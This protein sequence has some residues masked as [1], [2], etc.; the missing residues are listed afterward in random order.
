MAKKEKFTSGSYNLDSDLDLGNFDFG[1]EPKTKIKDDRS[2]VTKAAG[3]FA[4]GSI[5][6]MKSAVTNSATIAKAIR[7]GMPKEYGEVVDRTGE[8]TSQLSGLYNDANAKIKPEIQK[9]TKQIDKLVPEEMKRTKSVLGKI[10][11][12]LGVD[13]SSY[14]P[15]SEEERNEGNIQSNLAEVF[16]VQAEDSLKARAEDRAERKLDKKVDAKRFE[17]SFGL[18]NSINVNMA[19]MSNYTTKVNSA[20]QKKSLELQYRS[21]YVQQDTLKATKQLMAMLDER[22][23]AIQKNTGLPDFVKRHMSED[24]KEMTRRKLIGSVGGFMGRGI[25]NLA[26]HAKGKMDDY[27]NILQQ[28]SMGLDMAVDAKDMMKS[29]KEMSEMMGEEDLGK[30]GMVGD[31]AGGAVIEKLI[32]KFGKK[33]N[34]KYFQPGSKQSNALF[35]IL[36]VLN[37]GEQSARDFQKKHLQQDFGAEGF[38]GT[39]KNFAKGGLSDFID[40]F[41]GGKGDKSLDKQFGSGLNRLHESAEFNQL[42][43]KSITTIIPGFLSRIHGEIRALRTNK[44]PGQLLQF[45]AQTGKFDM[46]GKVDSS[47]RA[48]LQKSV[49]EGGMKY[50]ID[51]IHDQI[52]AGG[53]L[54][55]DASEALRKKLHHHTFTGIGL[56]V[57]DL[58]KDDFTKGM[59]INHARE[60]REAINKRYDK[61][62]ASY[63]ARRSE[64]TKAGKEARESIVK[65][66]EQ[67][68]KLIDAGHAENLVRLDIIEETSTGY[69][70]KPD[71][72][73]KLSDA[74]FKEDGLYKTSDL[75]SKT[76]IKNFSGAK[77]L[78][79]I[80]NTKVFN[81]LYKKGKGDGAEHVGPMAQDVRRNF[82]DET[83]PGGKAI[84]VVSM[85]GATMA[86]VQELD[87]KVKDNKGGRGA[88]ERNALVAIDKNTAAIVERLDNMAM[89][90]FGIPKLD[91]A[92]LK[93]AMKNGASKVG[94]KFSEGKEYLSEKAKMI[95]APEGIAEN[96]KLLAS[97]A[98]NILG[99]IINKAFDT[100]KSLAKK[101]GDKLEEL[102]EPAKDFLSKSKDKVMDASKW[103]FEKGT[104]F[105][106]KVFDKVSDVTTDI[107]Q[108]KLPAGW[109]QV[110]QAG[111]WLGGKLKNIVDTP[112]DIYVTGREKPALRAI[113]MRAGG[114]LD[115]I[116]KKPIKNP[117]DI[118][119]PV[120]DVDGNIVLSV[121]DIEAGI[122]DVNG[123]PIDSITTKIKSAIKNFASGAAEKASALFGKFKGLAGQAGSKAKD[124]ASKIHTPNIGIL[125]GV[126]VESILT[127]IRDVLNMRLPGKRMK[128]PALPSSTG[129][130]P[131]LAGAGATAT[132]AMD[133]VSGK[134]GELFDSAKDKVSNLVQNAKESKAFESGKNKLG[135]IAGNLKGSKFGSS[136]GGLFGK[137]GGMKGKVLSTVADKT[138]AMKHE[139]SDE[140]VGPKKQGLLSKIGGALSGFMG[141]GK[142][143]G[144]QST[145]QITDP[146]QIHAKEGQREGGVEQQFEMQAARERKRKS[147]QVATVDNAPR[148]KSNKN[149]FDSMADAAK[150][151][152][153]MVMN[154]LGSLANI[155]FGGGK[156]AGLLGT[157]AK[158]AL[159][160]AG[161]VAR[162][163]LSLGGTALR[164]G[165]GAVARFGA[166]AV[167]GGLGGAVGGIAG[168]AVA[169]GGA[170]L[171]ALSS[172]VVLGG[173]AVAAAG[174]G[175]YKGYKFLTRNKASAIT[176]VRMMQYG[177][178]NEDSSHNHEMFNLESELLQNG[179]VMQGRQFTIAKQKMNLK[180]ILDIFDLSEE[181]MG[182]ERGQ[183]F[184]TWFNQR[185]K[186]VFLTHL[187]ALYAVDPKFSLAEIDTLYKD[188]K[189][190]FDRYFKVATS[191]PDVY[192]SVESPF[193][194][195]PRLQV[196][197]EDVD[198]ALLMSGSYVNMFFI[199]SVCH[200]FF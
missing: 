100:T 173:L 157:V 156:V 126:R 60:I 110:L 125:A 34:S 78:N 31:L 120:I 178:R 133:S 88:T 15:E 184:I 181:Q 138:A 111:K 153:G 97:S 7:A 190:K 141:K 46:S 41:L 89:I 140:F 50:G 38:K 52:A 128:F 180:N 101:A 58:K 150:G 144:E 53:Q 96:A 87:K 93:E 193:E 27:L 55:A 70:I 9:I 154:G 42:T 142:S 103:F 54:S 36:S 18:L 164:M 105:A 33:L 148:Y 49:S 113:I 129:G 115:Q 6:G 136:I 186:T 19:R 80:K 149:I 90:N 102:K 162:G 26:T 122:H 183:N 194:D 82:G 69:N 112:I 163:A 147:Q 92:G 64:L 182:D 197:K 40:I 48:S 74:G 160:G 114:Y 172:P 12:A 130:T 165:A 161:M 73:R 11:K 35:N 158:G 24:F 17:S 30:A 66:E 192:A 143:G 56:D 152:F 65:P 14:R 107:I 59:D 108:N 116:T 29:Q 57:D 123:K 137:L 175:L 189:G 121:D 84:D 168:T 67:I 76:D 185:F 174:Y 28:A 43:Q 99:S 117:S 159:S 166:G 132:M 71:A 8:V 63:A 191:T 176:K 61:N 1:D 72:V 134:A 75:F 199:L 4:K 51:K 119:G 167:L 187:N 179:I 188:D 118:K 2:P 79:A 169:A 81:W 25:K 13:D 200:S 170:L 135:E 106:G 20:F 146:H 109:A 196:S 44:E 62:D 171:T 131:V 139:N 91:M 177:L 22:T 32:K 21:Y 151:A 68:Q 155:V 23:A 37:N 47:I 5:G 198:A 98:G 16:S 39:A 127:Q 94:E 195:L 95:K 45:N 77:A 3:N 86:A 10:K 85:N 104:K 124:L 145:E 83:A